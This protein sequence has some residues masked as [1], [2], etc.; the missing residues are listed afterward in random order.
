MK[1]ALP[2]YRIEENYT[3]VVSNCC[4]NRMGMELDRK[5]P[6]RMQC[7]LQELLKSQNISCI[8]CQLRVVLL[9][10]GIAFL[11][12]RLLNLKFFLLHMLWKFFVSASFWWLLRDSKSKRH[13]VDLRG[14]TGVVG[15]CYSPVCQYSSNETWQWLLS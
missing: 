14:A 11:E 4:I 3:T 13:T 1:K 6:S 7:F 5:V 15:L 2:C 10:N 9:N 8:N 12:S